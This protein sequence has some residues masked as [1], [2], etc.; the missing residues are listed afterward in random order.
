MRNEL[1]RPASRVREA[2]PENNVIKARLEQLQ[3]RLAGH[4]ALPQRGLENAAELFLKQAVLVAQLLLLAQGNGVVRLF[5]PGSL[6]AVHSRRIIFSLERLRGSKQWHSVAAADFRF[7]SGV[8]GHQ[9][10]ES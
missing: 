6:R 9:K 10:I 4:T 5:A 3:E 8:S 2:E 1:A 7:R